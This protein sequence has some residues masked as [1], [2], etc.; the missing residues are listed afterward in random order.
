MIFAYEIWTVRSGP[1]TGGSSAPP[2]APGGHAALTWLPPAPNGARMTTAVRASTAPIAAIFGARLLRSA[3][4]NSLREVSAAK[5]RDRSASCSRARPAVDRTDQPLTAVRHHSHEQWH[6]K[7]PGVLAS[8]R[9]IDIDQSRNSGWCVDRSGTWPRLRDCNRQD[10]RR[11]SA[12]AET[13]VGGI[14]RSREA[15]RQFRSRELFRTLNE[16][17]IGLG[18]RGAL[19]EQIRPALHNLICSRSRLGTRALRLRRRGS[20]RARGRARNR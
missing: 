17:G 20:Q 19:I 14:A 15:I 11:P 18:C 13:V 9:N 7:F 1:L 16:L 2:G 12:R 5:H 8:R 10:R 4:P 3:K 6:G